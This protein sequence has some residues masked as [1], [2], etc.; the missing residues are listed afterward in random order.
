MSE[1]SNR[2][3]LNCFL[4]NLFCLN[5]KANLHFTSTPKNQVDTYSLGEK[6]DRDSQTDD[7][8]TGRQTD[9]QTDQQTDKQTDRQ[10]KIN[11]QMLS[12]GFKLFPYKAL[13]SLTL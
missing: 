1:H 6:R 8:Q 3:I 5:N 2:T 7:A 12:T 10:K 11:M 9:R 4:A 13:Q